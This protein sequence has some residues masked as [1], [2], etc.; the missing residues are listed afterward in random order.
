M[1]PVQVC[2][3]LGLMSLGYLWHQPQEQLLDDM[4]HSGIH[5]VLVKVRGVVLAFVT[6][7]AHMAGQTLSP[8][9][10]GGGTT[11]VAL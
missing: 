8:C 4:I 2:S 6:S 1:D 11:V 10:W 9:V 7:Q 5:A 3:R